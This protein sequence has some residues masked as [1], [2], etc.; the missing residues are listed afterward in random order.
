MGTAG[1]S[2]EH[3]RSNGKELVHD[4]DSS[5]VSPDEFK[6]V[7]RN[8]PAGVAV[9]TADGGEGPVGMT[10]T[11]VFS[12]SLDPPLLTFSVSQQSSSTPTILR[13]DTVVVHLLDADQLDIAILCATSGVDRFADTTIWSRLETREP[14]F[15]GARTWVRGRVVSKLVAGDSTLIVV[16]ALQTSGATVIGADEARPLVYHDRTWH[17]LGDGSRL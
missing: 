15:H 6:G 13:A 12:V 16:Q 9:I 8:H 3:P 11:S 17:A 10:A 7:F 5:F 2:R 4:L 1:H 14:Y